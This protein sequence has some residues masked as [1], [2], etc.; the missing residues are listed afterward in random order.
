M[1]LVRGGIKIDILELRFD[2]ST[3][4]KIKI[5]SLTKCVL[6]LVPPIKICRI[7]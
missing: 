7:N 3:G 6:D 5:T 1:D 2:F 4:V